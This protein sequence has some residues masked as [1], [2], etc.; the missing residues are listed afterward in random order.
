MRISSTWQRQLA[1]KLVKQGVLVLPSQRASWA[2]AMR[3]EIAHI[4]DDRE[5]LKWALGSFRACL[6]ER[7]RSHRMFSA[8]AIGILWIALFVITSAYNLLIALAA[9]LGFDH[10]VSSLGWWMRDFQ[11]DRFSRFANAMPVGLFAFLGAVVLLFAASLSLNLRR[12]PSGF[13]TFCCA[14]GLSC[15]AWMYQLCIPAYLEAIST[16]HRWRI[17][18][19]FVLTAVI[20][21]ALRIPAPASSRTRLLAGRLQ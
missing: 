7:L 15:A 19:C 14:I 18:I 6:T 8:R 4:D 2:V 12:R 17:G 9:R 10:A 13:A 3:S 5:A 11:Y 1:L 16:P 20:L 21:S